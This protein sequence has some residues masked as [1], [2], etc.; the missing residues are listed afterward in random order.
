MEQAG[1]EPLFQAADAPAD[2]GV[3]GAGPRRAALRVP[4]RATA[5]KNRRSSQLGP[6]L[7]MAALPLCIDAQR[8]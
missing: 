1:A 2:R 3:L 5:R 7:A 8:L 6:V 4:V